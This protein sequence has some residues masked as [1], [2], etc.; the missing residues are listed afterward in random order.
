MTIAEMKSFILGELKDERRKLL[1]GEQNNYGYLFMISNDLGLVTLEEVM[2]QEK[3]V[4][5][6]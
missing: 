2:A 4:S 1:N 6:G 5:I 3:V